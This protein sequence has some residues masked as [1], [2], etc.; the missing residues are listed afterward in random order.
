MFLRSRDNNSTSSGGYWDEYS[1]ASES[2]MERHRDPKHNRRTTS[3]TREESYM[4]SLNAHPSNGEEDFV[5]ET[6]EAALVAA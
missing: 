6:P 5:Q 3:Q 4:K 1:D 2:S